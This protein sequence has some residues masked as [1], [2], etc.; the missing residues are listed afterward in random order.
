MQAGAD[1]DRAAVPGHRTAGADQ[2]RRHFPDERRAELVEVARRARYRLLA[3]LARGKR[4]L[5][6]ACGTGEGCAVLAEAGA[7]EVIGLGSEAA[8]LDAVRER[9]PP[10]V[11]LELGD[12]TRLPFDDESFALIACL[13][14]VEGL[15]EPASALDE[16][17]RLL[18]RGGVLA[19]SGQV[20]AELEQEL[21]RRLA[22]V[23]VFR[24]Q[25]WVASAVVDEEFLAA[26][27]GSDARGLA[28]HKPADWRPGPESGAVALASDVPLPAVPQVLLPAG[29]LDER[30]W[31]EAVDRQ[32][33]IIDAQASRIVELEAADAERAEI[34]KR[35]AEAEQE[36]ARL[37]ELRRRSEELETIISS[38]GWRLA[39]ALRVPRERASAMWLPGLRRRAKHLLAV[40][41]RYIRPG[42]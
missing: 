27:A 12:V 39:V 37:P 38:P 34:R 32:Q 40:L 16:L 8:V 17:S 22:N 5:D 36:L 23:R 13:D 29:G 28:V 10:Q 30:R 42:R 21:A 18:A 31:A 4:V 25:W 19:L 20:P 2:P 15:E 7:T 14:G 11:R 33:E 41:M 24:Q 26:P 1:T 3:P 35:L 9:M 6:A